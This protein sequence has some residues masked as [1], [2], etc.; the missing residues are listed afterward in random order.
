M[1]VLV[2]GTK[3]VFRESCY[4]YKSLLKIGAIPWMVWE[5]ERWQDPNIKHLQIL[6]DALTHNRNIYSTEGI[7]DFMLHKVISSLET[8]HKSLSFDIFNCLV[9]PGYCPCFFVSCLQFLNSTTFKPHHTFISCMYK[10][11]HSYSSQTLLA[12]EPFCFSFD[13]YPIRYIISSSLFYQVS[14]ALPL[15]G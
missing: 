14:G 9:S 12:W 13:L 3:L 5:Q 10:F 8:I 11:T 2:P 15:R 7:S 4:A 6:I 1:L